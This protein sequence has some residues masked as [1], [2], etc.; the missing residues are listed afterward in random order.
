MPSGGND[1]S[2]FWGGYI[3]AIIG[4]VCTVIGVYWIIEYSQENNKEDVR[5][6]VLPYMALTVLHK[7]I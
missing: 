3:G 2:G 1:W 5:K 4:G 6:R 7:E